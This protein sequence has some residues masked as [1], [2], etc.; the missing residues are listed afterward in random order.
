M[1]EFRD[2]PV[3]VTIGKRQSP[4]LLEDLC[5]ALR[6]VAVR[7]GSLPNSEEARDAVQEVV[8]IAK[9]LE[10]REVRTT[11]RIDQLS[12]ETGWLMDQLLDD[13]R[14]FPETIPYVRESDGIRRY[15]R[16]Q[17]CKSAERPE[18]DVHYSACNA[19]LQKIIDSI[20]SLE[21][22]GG[23]VLF[24]TYN[25]DWRCEHANSETVLIG[26][27]CYEE[28]FLGPGECKQCIENTLAQRRQKT[29]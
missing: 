15:Y 4:E 23:T 24:R 12:Q 28:G 5:I 27:D 9:E 14:K 18:D 10:V 22:V 1:T 11:D 6:G 21:P 17:Y 29:E 19:C 3:R 25:T 2:T 26:V 20:D 16:C 13:C 7:D 8:L